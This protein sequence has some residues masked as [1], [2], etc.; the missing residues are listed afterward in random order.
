M[1]HAF[2]MLCYE[3]EL[4]LPGMMQWLG[5][6]TPNLD[7]LDED[8]EW[9]EGHAWDTTLAAL[10]LVRAQQIALLERFEPAAWE[11]PRDR[12][13]WDRWAPEGGVTLRWVLTKTVQHTAEHTHS[14]LRLALMWDYSARKAATSIPPLKGS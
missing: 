8:A 2:H 1:R 4:V 13:P 10:R 6:A 9:T 5:G 7:A 3:R 12:T 14:V 11:E